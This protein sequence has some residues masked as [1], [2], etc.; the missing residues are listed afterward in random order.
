MVAMRSRQPPRDNAFIFAAIAL[1][2][3][4]AF[5]LVASTVPRWTVPL[6]TYDMVLKIDGPYDAARP[7][8]SMDFGVR[9]NRVV[10]IVTPVASGGYSWRRNLLLV[11]HATLTAKEI[12]FTAPDRL[13]EGESERVIVIDALATTPVSTAVEAPDGYALRTPDMSGGPGL[14][15][16]IFGMRSYRQRITLFS[17]GRG[18]NITLPAPFTDAYRPI[19]FVGWVTRDERR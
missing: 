17:R 11:D 18:V 3:V 4:A 5:F 15:G 14:I 2:L 7:S 16:E 13:N 9:D 12:P 10:A 8:T 6:P 1:P 19:T